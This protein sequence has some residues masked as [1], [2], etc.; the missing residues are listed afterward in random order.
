MADKRELDQKK[1]WQSPNDLKN[2]QYFHNRMLLL[3][4]VTG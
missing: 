3:K 2:P 1:R 4:P